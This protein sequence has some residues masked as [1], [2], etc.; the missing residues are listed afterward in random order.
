VDKMTTINVDIDA[1]IRRMRRKDGFWALAVEH[2]A[3]Y[4]GRNQL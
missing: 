2:E 3:K 1:R 4:E